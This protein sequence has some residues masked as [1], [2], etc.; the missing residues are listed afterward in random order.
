MFQVAQAIPALKVVGL[1]VLI[2]PGAETRGRKNLD[3][4]QIKGILCHHTAGPYTGD[5]PSLNIV[6]DGRPDLAGPLAHFVLARSGDVHFIAGGRCNHAG[7][8]V[9]H[10]VLDGNLH[11]IGIEA[12]NA[13]YLTDIWNTKNG[14]KEGT[15]VPGTGALHIIHKADPWPEV[16]M[17]A[18]AKLCAALAV[19]YGFDLQ[20]V[21]GHKEYATPYGRKSDPSFDMDEFRNV[22]VKPRIA[23]FKSLIT[24]LNH[25]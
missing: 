5:A 21:A 17:I 11:M 14:L 9:W 8:G 7:A 23:Q 3:M 6:L 12:E 13:G 18:Y 2:Q 10:D 24:P 22:E 20:M 15:L 19:Y 16:Q 1:N 4:G 25:S